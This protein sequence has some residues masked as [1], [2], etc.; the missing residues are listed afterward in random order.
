MEQAWSPPEGDRV[1]SMEEDSRIAAHEQL[2]VAWRREAQALLVGTV[3]KTSYGTIYYKGKAEGKPA[4][5]WWQ[6]A[7]TGKVLFQG[8][9]GRAKGLV[10]GGKSI[11]TGGEM[12]QIIAMAETVRFLPDGIV[13]LTGK[14]LAIR[15]V[16]EQSGESSVTDMAARSI[17]VNLD[18]A[19]WR[20]HP[21]PTVIPRKLQKMDLPFVEE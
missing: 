21:R 3:I 10:V 15:V 13:I 20:G 19:S 7:I 6:G 1:G 18:D 2:S 14:P 17:R 11:I 9:R 8:K 16:T 4:S 12:V 5:G